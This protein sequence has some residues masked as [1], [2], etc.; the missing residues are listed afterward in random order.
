[1][2]SH[3][4]QTSVFVQT[5]KLFKKMLFLFHLVAL[6]DRETRQKLEKGLFLKKHIFKDGYCLCGCTD[7]I[8]RELCDASTAL[9]HS[10]ILIID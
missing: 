2:A 8:V 5:T 9:C 1:M 4:E 6:P 3:L 7:L 10:V